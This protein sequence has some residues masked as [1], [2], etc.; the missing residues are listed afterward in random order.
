MA[1]PILCCLTNCSIA[2][3]KGLLA[4]FD[5]VT[6]R[7]AWTKIRPSSEVTELTSSTAAADCK[8]SSTMRVELGRSN[9]G[10]AAEPKGS[11]GNTKQPPGS[12]NCC[13]WLQRHRL[14]FPNPSPC[15][16]RAEY[17]R[18]SWYDTA[19]GRQVHRKRLLA[20]AAQS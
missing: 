6:L 11:A 18:S 15:L 3:P 12:R 9:P 14:M 16:H 7:L 17:M 10:C 13:R 4:A 2:L 8:L 1:T 20:L 19:P 5:K